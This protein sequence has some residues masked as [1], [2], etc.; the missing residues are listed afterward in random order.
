MELFG[1][2]AEDFSQKIHDIHTSYIHQAL[3]EPYIFGMR[4]IESKTLL[5]TI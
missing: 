2:F 4:T 3:K 1:N 5:L